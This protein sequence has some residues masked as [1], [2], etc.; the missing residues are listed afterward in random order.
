MIKSLCLL[1]WIITFF[2]TNLANAGQDIEKVREIANEYK[3]WYQNRLIE[4]PTVE[5]LQD[6]FEVSQAIFP[7]S[8]NLPTIGDAKKQ[9]THPKFTKGKTI[10]YP[11]ELRVYLPAEVDVAILIDESGAPID[12]FIINS[13]NER[14]NDSVISA[15]RS[16]QFKPALID[17][18]PC[19]SVFLVPVQLGLPSSTK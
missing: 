10:K 11:S 16:W 15:V 5:E 13:S 7:N 14:F 6:Y 18:L 12:T 1:V 8:P 19:K 17:H 3:E 2:A 4:I 9:W